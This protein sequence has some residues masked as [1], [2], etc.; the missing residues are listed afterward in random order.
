[1][2]YSEKTIPY[3]LSQAELEN[4]QIL[5]RRTQSFR[6]MHDVEV[7]EGSSEETDACNSNPDQLKKK[8]A[9]KSS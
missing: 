7:E 9:G 8:T 3:R 2:K 1:L 6:S 5:R 4:L